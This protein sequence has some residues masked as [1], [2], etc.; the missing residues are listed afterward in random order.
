M[1][2]IDAV[3]KPGRQELP[4]FRRN[5]V[6]LSKRQKPHDHTLEL[7]SYPSDSQSIGE[8]AS[9]SPTHQPA[10]SQTHSNYLPVYASLTTKSPPNE[11]APGP[12][13][14]TNKGLDATESVRK[15]EPLQDTTPQMDSPVVH[16]TL[17]RNQTSLYETSLR[18][19]S[20]V[21][22]TSNNL[23]ENKNLTNNLP[24][25]PPPSRNP[26]MGTAPLSS[27]PPLDEPPSSYHSAEDETSPSK[28]PP[29]DG[30][31]PS[32]MPPVDGTSPSKRPPAGGTLPSSHPPMI[33]GTSPSNHPSVDKTPPSKNPPMSYISPINSHSPL[34]RS[35]PS[36]HSQA[37]GTSS[38]NHPEPPIIDRTSPSNQPDEA[39]YGKCLPMDKPPLRKHPSTDFSDSQ[40]SVNNSL[41]GTHPPV[42]VPSRTNHPDESKLQSK[43][44]LPASN[45]DQTPS[46]HL[47]VFRTSLKFFSSQVSSDIAQLSNQPPADDKPCDKQTQH[48]TPSISREKVCNMQHTG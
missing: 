24:I 4:A 25:I 31:S 42:E 22:E 35:R 47:V 26:P 41:P 21:G 3:S 44:E 20:S 8:T 29:L 23:P 9:E 34:D 6:S 15:F 2:Y 13:I 7:E 46:N 36:Q 30:S 27:H 12:T 18:S 11:T 37:L 32:N 14:E 33:S 39:A 28:Q 17:A 43:N 5:E 16:K 38:S 10:V 45:D 1:L 19:D 40:Q 48:E